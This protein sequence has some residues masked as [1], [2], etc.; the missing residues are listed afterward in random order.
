[1]PLLLDDR[2]TLRVPKQAA[3]AKDRKVKS[4][5]P[6]MTEEEEATKGKRMRKVMKGQI[7][8]S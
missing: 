6:V 3:A 8:A 1:M 2:F 7:A 5:R 4:Y